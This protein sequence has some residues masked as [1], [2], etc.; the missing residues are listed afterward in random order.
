MAKGFLYILSNAA[1][2]DL[3][4]IGFS[5]KVPTERAEELFTTGVPSPF[6]IEYYCL[7]EGN[8][9]LESQVHRTLAEHRHREDREYFRVDVGT[10]VSAIQSMCAPEHT[11]SRV[12]IPQ[13]RPAV[14][15]CTKCG[16]SYRT[17]V[18]C[19]VCQIKLAW[20]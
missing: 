13:P 5:R 11:W 9:E 4:K 12:P 8:V 6:V 16:A 7:V 19:P 20:Q 1:F 17:A 3:L 18:Y 14:V 10:V 15:E 2:P